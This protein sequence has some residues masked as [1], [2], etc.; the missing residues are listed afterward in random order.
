M[1]EHDFEAAQ[2]LPEIPE[3]IASDGSPVDEKE[4]S[5]ESV[6]RLPLKKRIPSGNNNPS[7]RRDRAWRESVSRT[8]NDNASMNLGNFNPAAAWAPRELPV[9]A[10]D[11]VDLSTLQRRSI[12]DGWRVAHPETD[13]EII[14]RTPRNVS[15]RLDDR[16]LDSLRKYIGLHESSEPLQSNFE[17]VASVLKGKYERKLSVRPGDP[18]TLVKLCEDGV[19]FEIRKVPVLCDGPHLSECGYATA[20]TFR[21]SYR[22]MKVPLDG[23]NIE[24]QAIEQH[25]V[26]TILETSV[27]VGKV[28]SPSQL[29][30][31]VQFAS[32][33]PRMKPDTIAKM[34]ETRPEIT[35]SEALHGK[36][37]QKSANILAFVNEEMRLPVTR[38]GMLRFADNEE[39]TTRRG[40]RYGLGALVEYGTHGKDGQIKWHE[41]S[42]EFTAPRGDGTVSS[43]IDEKEAKKR[44]WMQSPNQTG[45][46]SGALSSGNSF[47]C[48]A[49]VKPPNVGS[50]AAMS[51]NDLLD[52]QVQ[53]K[54][55]RL[56]APESHADLLERREMLTLVNAR[57]SANTRKVLDLLRGIG[58]Q[59]AKTLA[60]IGNLVTR[61][62][63]PDN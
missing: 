5:I 7:I 39:R 14:P 63:G 6:E 28:R 55:G 60:E 17:R 40:Q 35:M 30:R 41:V 49:T 21:H 24:R 15:A 31:A 10:N 37:S 52:E 12:L 16:Q 23:E 42:D 44:G 48:G 29:L 33:L 61:K 56:E 1:I 19:D 22:D 62:R 11:N 54:R 47:Q 59:A 50:M 26:K 3:H 20:H 46:L 58:G 13:S 51:T 38:I 2:V 43:T 36:R 32:R 9:A 53:A 18:E 27:M 8:A 25:N 57:L 34:R 45:P 4:V